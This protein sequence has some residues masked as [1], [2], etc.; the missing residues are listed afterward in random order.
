[1]EAIVIFYNI[2]QKIKKDNIFS[3]FRFQRKVIKGISYETSNTFSI[4][5]LPLLNLN[6]IAFSKNYINKLNS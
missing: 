1:M 6:P 3:F 5:D 4:F 2:L